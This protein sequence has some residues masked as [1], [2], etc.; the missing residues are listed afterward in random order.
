MRKQF[1]YYI[2]LILITLGACSPA[3]EWD[4]MYDELVDAEDASYMLIADLELAPDSY[5]LASSDYAYSSNSDVS[6]YSNF[7]ADATAKDYMPE[8]LYSLFYGEDEQTIDV[9]YTYYNGSLDYLDELAAGVEYDYAITLTTEDYDSDE[10]TSYYDNFDLRDG[11]EYADA[12]A[13]AEALGAMLELNHDAVAD[14]Y[15]AVTYD[16][17]DGSSGEATE[18]I[19]KTDGVWIMAS[20]VVPDDVTVYTLDADDY[21]SMGEDYGE[22]GYYNNFSSTII[23]A[24]YIPT[25]L[26]NLYPY[27]SEGDIVAVVYAYYSG[28]TY[29]VAEQYTYSGSAWE[30]Y[31]VTEEV[32]STFMFNVETS[33][34]NGV[35]YNDYSISYW[36]LQSDAV[37]LSEITYTE[38]TLTDADYDLDDLTSYYDNFDL[39]DGKD[40]ADDTARAAA[41]GVMLETNYGAGSDEYYLVTYDYYDGSSGEATELLMKT[42]GVWTIYAYEN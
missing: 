34:E 7:S 14:T 23:A 41:I 35:T 18:I 19:V 5:T 11:Y 31:E 26:A 17:Y 8:I 30:A 33:K 42:D 13:R 39:R 21:D 20:V 40:Y 29:D 4:D 9:T 37:Y 6:T 24:N 3:D 15:Y 32:T 27:A 2:G 10:Y 38:V 12:D 22:P 36:E 16:Y 1:I 28:S 25:F